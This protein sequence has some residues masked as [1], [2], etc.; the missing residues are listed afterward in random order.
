MKTYLLLVNNYDNDKKNCNL[1]K[2][3]GRSL[4]QLINN[5]CPI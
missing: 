4:R 1:K 2:K 5:F 3:Y